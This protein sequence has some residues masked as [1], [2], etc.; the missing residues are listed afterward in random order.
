MNTALSHLVAERIQEMLSNSR[1]ESFPDARIERIMHGQKILKPAAVLMPLFRYNDEWHLLFTRRA[2]NLTDHKGQVSFP[3]G[4]L[5]EKD[6]DLQFTALR[7]TQ[8][9]IGIDPSD[10]RILGCLPRRELVS[11]YIVTPVIGQI[12]WPYPLRIFDSEVA[13]VFSIP[14]EWLFEEENRFLKWHN[15]LGQDFQV[16]YYRN[17]DG[18]T[19]WGASA[20]MTLELVD[21]LRESIQ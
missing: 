11:G 8:E 9:E 12:P 10:V 2:D 1:L 4:A 13:R 16:L 15:F 18:E 17:Y 19:L 5:E 6:P 3:G 7:E 21:A 14:L 20:S